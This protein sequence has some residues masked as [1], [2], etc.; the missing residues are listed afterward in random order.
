MALASQDRD[1]LR[2]AV[3]LLEKKRY[4]ARLTHYAGQPIEQMMQAL[5]QRAADRVH[6]L[7]R[8]TVTRLLAVA[9]KTMGRDAGRQARPR[10]HKLAGGISGA[11]GGAFG[12]SALAVELP[13]STTIMLR[14]IADIARSE[15]EDLTTV[16]SRLACLEVFA[17]GGPAAGDDA[18]DTG[19][20]TVRAS[21]AKALSEAVQYI[22]RKGLT[23]QGAPVLVR[24]ISQIAARFGALVSEKAAAQAV[25]IIGAA[26]GAGINLMFLTHFQETARGHFIIRRLER[27][28]GQAAVQ[29][30]YRELS[31]RQ[32]A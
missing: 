4:I 5:P 10:M 31:D 18:G 14:S 9:L 23:D 27:K 26:G 12:L 1:D 19:Y 30:A 20:Y 29:A 2:F 15:G 22:A 8:S 13:L 11:V 24:F 17:L 28:Y 32:E 21:L 7:V 3:G 16:E 25:P 6:K